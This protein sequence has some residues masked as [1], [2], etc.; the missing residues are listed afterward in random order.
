MTRS[1]LTLGS[2]ACWTAW[3]GSSRAWWAPGSGVLLFLSALVDAV[4]AA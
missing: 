4:R 2:A 3:S 1:L